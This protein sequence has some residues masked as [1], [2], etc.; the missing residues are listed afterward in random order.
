MVC[1]PVVEKETGIVTVP[2]DRVAGEPDNG[3]PPSMK[4]TVPVGVPPKAEVTFAVRLIDV[5]TVVGFW[6]E[7]TFVEVTA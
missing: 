3:L 4:L 6:E 2:D 5:E 7:I 1:R